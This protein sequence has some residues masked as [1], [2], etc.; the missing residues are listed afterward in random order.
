MLRLPVLRTRAFRPC[1]FSH[2]LR[3]AAS[4]APP[5]IRIKDATFYENYPSSEDQAKDQNPPLFPKL[6]FNLPSEPGEKGPQHWAVIGASNRTQFL[7]VLRGQYISI[8]PNSRTY[9]Y[10]STDEIA[11]KDPWLRHPGNAIQYVGFSAEGSGAIGGT[12]GAYL[13]ARYESLREETD[14]T[15]AQYLK[16]QTSLNPLEE[17][18]QGNIRDDKWLLEVIRELHLEELLD[19]P[20][21]NLSNGQT[22]RARIAK[23]LLRKPELLL[24]DDPFLGLDPATVRSISDLLHRLASKSDPRLVLSLRPQDTLPDWITHLLILGNFNTVLAQGSR[25]DIKATYKIWYKALHRMHT[26]NKDPVYKRR[27]QVGKQ[28]LLAGYLDTQLMRD[29]QII[30]D[31]LKEISIP[32]QKG[33][34]ALVEMDGVRVQYGENKVVLGNW[35]QNIRAKPKDGLH[36]VVRRGQ[37]WVILGANGSGKTT[38]LSLITS[39]HPQAYAL[40]IKLFG[41]SR[42]P[43][44][45]QP[46]ISIFELQSRIGHSS[47]E[48]HAF[49]PRQLTIR[50]ALETAFAETF[51]SKPSLNHERDQDVSAALRFFKEQLD[52][53][54]NAADQQPP[55]KVTIDRTRFPQT[56]R[57]YTNVMKCHP[58]EFEIEYADTT[59]FGQ[60]STA[61]Q[62]LVL[63]LRAL[64]HKP[65]LVI[66]DEPFSGMSASLRDKCIH[67]LEIGET[68]NNKQS[69]ASRRLGPNHPLLRGY[70]SGLRTPAESLKP[71]PRHFGLSD[72]Q[73]LIMISHV[74]EEIPDSVRHFMRLPSGDQSDP[75]ALDFRCGYMK[76]TSMLS[77]A[78]VW[79]AAWAPGPKF[80]RDMNARK[81]FRRRDPKADEEEE[82][83]FDED[84]YEWWSI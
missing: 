74:R 43:E 60:L 17:Q 25:S 19:M 36:W 67:F 55:P 63:F 9:P 18:K 76:N 51:L 38:L 34:E 44:P 82:G 29:L 46:G 32:A 83:E 2:S 14:W 73:A 72:D 21:A 47:P 15:V 5:L 80:T 40:P 56:A 71:P 26:T 22:R 54:F 6:D 49:F 4:A 52:L 45:G 37:R 42:L 20:V 66:L 62:R 7:D 48:I 3:T 12:R 10:L 1:S 77:N 79:D 13:S 75:Q 27:F 41:R 16:G 33:G 35:T 8:P 39:D 61:Q 30:P 50:Q 58:I 28:N 84:I 81:A 57:T 78:K 64:V 59:T 68:L 70:L 11:K 53:N 24:L 65:D 69:H 31:K 23:A